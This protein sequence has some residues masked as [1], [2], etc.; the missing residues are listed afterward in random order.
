M[1]DV[2]KHFSKFTGKNLYQSLSFNDVA[3]LRET[4]SDSIIYATNSTELVLT[5]E[6]V[7]RRKGNSGFSVLLDILLNRF[8]QK[9]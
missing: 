7:Y 6:F 2:L 5:A 9:Y 1:E 4:A 8:F 3:S